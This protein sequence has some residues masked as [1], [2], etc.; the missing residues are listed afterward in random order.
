MRNL[1]LGL[2]AISSQL[3]FGQNHT[4]Y[5]IGEPDSIATETSAKPYFQLIT[6]KFS[7]AKSQLLITEEELLNAG[8]KAGHK[9]I[10]IRW[11]VKSDSSAKKKVYDLYL[12]D[13][14]SDSSQ[15]SNAAVFVPLN[16]SNKVG[17]NLVDSGKVNG[18]HTASLDNPFEWDGKDHMVIQ[19]CKLSGDE[20][21]EDVIT[22]EMPNYL[23]KYFIG[24]GSNGQNCAT[25]K[26]NV[27]TPF[28]PILQIV[29]K[30][31]KDTTISITACGKFSPRQGKEWTSSGDY[32]DTIPSKIGDC[33]SIITYKLTINPKPADQKTKAYACENYK[34]AARTDK[35]TTYTI[36]GRYTY[37]AQG[38]N[39]Q[40]DTTNVLE[41]EIGTLSVYDTIVQCEKSYT[42]PVNKQVYDRSGDY[43]HKLTFNNVC[44][45]MYYLHLEI[46]PFKKTLADTSKKGEY[47][48]KLAN[49][50]IK[51]NY[52]SD[53]TVTYT[54]VVADGC[55]TLFTLNLTFNIPTKN[56]K[57]HSCDDYTWA[58]NTKTYDEDTIVKHLVEFTGMEADTVFVLDLDHGVYLQDPQVENVCKTFTWE[59]NKAIYKESITVSDT[60]EVANACDTIRTLQLTINRPVADT[61]RK[62]ECNS[63]SW[64]LANAN[65]KNDTI[66]KAIQPAPTAAAC[67]TVFILDLEVVKIDTTTAINETLN[68]IVA[69][70]ANANAKYQWFDCDNND[71]KLKDSTRK[72]IQHKAGNFKVEITIGKCKA[73][74]TCL[75]LKTTSVNELAPAI[76]MKTFPN[77]TSGAMKIELEN[78]QELSFT[79]YSVDG[80][81]IDQFNSNGQ[82]LIEYTL[83]AKPGIYFLEA[84]S[85]NQ[86][87]TLIIEKF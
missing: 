81:S 15:L 80:R 71:T 54:K 62:T 13:D 55:D 5:D 10:E 11:H 70:E 40:C 64:A 21:P 83:E 8:L 17:T 65:L 73:T 9:I 78:A 44:D 77:P 49:E 34:W 75:S 45:T 26:G 59:A 18:W 82:S 43:E 69:K 14:Y 36:S 12:T 72:M 2:C 50:K 24:T 19:F 53:T 76:G 38:K 60:L 29:A 42:W 46:A 39:G 58:R 52:K 27:S 85:G 25:V 20:E 67:D 84:R 63:F 6:S 32:M 56:E 35:D 47:D 86:T 1:L 30:C 3:A 41:L 4:V 7:T 87:S 23:S 66:I 28:R 57:V 31:Q 74:S 33:D 16:A 51:Y 37:I 68:A 61:I 79:I 48:W 22:R